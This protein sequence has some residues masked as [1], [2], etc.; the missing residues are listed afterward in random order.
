MIVICPYCRAARDDHEHIGR[1]DAEPQ[2]GDVN[3]CYDCHEPSI[4]EGAAGSLSLRWPSLAEYAEILG[5]PKMRAIAAALREHPAS[6]RDAIDA[7][8]R[9]VQP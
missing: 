8:R 5:H 6:R 7:A 3:V 9:A 2:P 4:F 1:P